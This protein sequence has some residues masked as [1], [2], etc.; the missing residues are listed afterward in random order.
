[1]CYK[2]WWS[3]GVS[4]T[5]P[6]VSAFLSPMSSA[7]QKAFFLESKFG[8]FA[9]RTTDIPKVGPGEVLVKVEAAALNPLDWAIQAFGVFV[10]KYPAVLGC[11]GAGTVVQLG[12]GVTSLVVGDRM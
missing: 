7:Q 5:D 1:M 2:S 8:Q 3:T 4:P 6:Q 9:V 10:D 11:D 12:E